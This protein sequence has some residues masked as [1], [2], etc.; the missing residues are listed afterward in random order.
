MDLVQ[1]INFQNLNSHNEYVDFVISEVSIGKFY[2]NIKVN[3]VNKTNQ[4]IDISL[5]ESYFISKDKIQYD[6]SIST[7][8][9]HLIIL[10]NVAKTTSYNLTNSISKD[11]KFNSNDLLIATFIINN[12]KFVIG[13]KIG[14]AK[15]LFTEPEKINASPK[16]Q[17][18]GCY[19]LSLAFS[20]LFFVFLILII[21]LGYI[22]RNN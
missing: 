5:T 16:P 8:N 4:I 14:N 12:T 7:L 9:N 13:C 6:I 15:G 17:K 20:I 21:V 10:P 3:V 1:N 11:Y 19:Y 18:S 22:S 2:P